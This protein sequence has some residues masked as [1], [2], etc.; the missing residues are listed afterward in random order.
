V[1]PDGSGQAAHAWTG[2]VLA[3]GRASRFGG[4]D[5][6]SLLIEGRPIIV[7]QLEA[8][9]ALTPHLLIVG[10]GAAR[11]EAFGAPTVPDA[12]AGAGPLGGLYTALL[13]ASTPQV[14]VVACD[15]PHVDARFLGFLAQAGRDAEAAVPRTSDGWHPLCASYASACAARLRARLEAGQLKVA[16]ALTDLAVREIGP[17]ELARFDPR[18]LANINT[19]DDYRRLLP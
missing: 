12:I 1:A 8:F 6:A 7:R 19:E 13:R 4:R 17:D 18:V 5:K 16:D 9:R 3:G 11:H 14:V 10:N 15:M 2:V